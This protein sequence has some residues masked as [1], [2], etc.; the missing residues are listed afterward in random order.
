MLAK[1]AKIFFHFRFLDNR[2]NFEKQVAD[3]TATSPSFAF[4]LPSVE[5]IIILAEL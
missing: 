3:A 1:Y 2:T 4:A 5:E